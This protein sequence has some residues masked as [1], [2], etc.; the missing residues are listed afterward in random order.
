MLT[1]P[2]MASMKIKVERKAK[3]RN[4]YNQDAHLTQ[5][6]IWKNDKTQNDNTQE[7]Q[8]VS[9]LTAGDHKAAMNRNKTA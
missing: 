9:H 2:A 7:N 3:I 5:D 1:I 8:E 4:G 6:T